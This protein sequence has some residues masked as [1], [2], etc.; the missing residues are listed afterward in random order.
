M[1]H[2]EHGH[3]EKC[4]ERVKRGAC[5]AQAGR[6][7]FAESIRGVAWRS[8]RRIA[9][10]KTALCN[11]AEQGRPGGS[12]GARTALCGSRKVVGVKGKNKRVEPNPNSRR[13]ALQGHDGFGSLR[14]L[15]RAVGGRR[16]WTGGGA[17][18]VA[19]TRR[20]RGGTKHVHKMLHVQRASAQNVRL[21][22][23][24]FSKTFVS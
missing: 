14:D 13:G 5:Y 11:V 3:K 12:G 10:A 22:S 17:M 2:W 18:S 21:V 8:L 19:D 15:K 23:G 20:V 16:A 1:E 7:A 9:S 24:H 4:N 6:E